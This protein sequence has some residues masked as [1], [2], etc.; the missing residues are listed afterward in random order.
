MSAD[1]RDE[2][3]SGG[4]YSLTEYTELL[5]YSLILSEKVQLLLQHHAFG[6]L[7]VCLFV[8]VMQYMP[9]G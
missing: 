6:N 8:F 7:F 2:Q 9:T 5:E 1:G 3:D 4:W